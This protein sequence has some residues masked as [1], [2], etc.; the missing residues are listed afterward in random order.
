MRDDGMTGWRD[1]G[2][3]GAGCGMRDDGRGTFGVTI[4]VIQ[5]RHTVHTLH[6]YSV[7]T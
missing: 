5:G 7:H 4:R 6:M 1:G 3:R 2:M